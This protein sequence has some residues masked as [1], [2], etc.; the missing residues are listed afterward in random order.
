MTVYVDN[1]QIPYGRMKMSHMVADTEDELRAMAKAIGVDVRHHQHPGT[2]KSHFDIC[3][4]KRKLAIEQGAIAV[5]SKRLV[6]ML[7]N[8]GDSKKLDPGRMPSVG[9]IAKRVV[10][11]VNR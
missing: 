6:L 7:R 3:Q 10:R 9:E 5:S 2:W 4:S 11:E 8:R 1:G